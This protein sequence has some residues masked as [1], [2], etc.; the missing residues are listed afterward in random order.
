MKALILAAGYGTRLYSIIKDTPKALLEVNHK[1]LVNYI[2]DRLRNVKDLNEVI[3]VTNEK[4]ASIFEE[5]AAAQDYFCPIRIVNDGT[6]T[7]EDRLG[8]IG[9]IDFAIKQASVEDDLLVVGGDNLF[10]FNIEEYIVFAR[11]Q[12]KSVTIGCYDIE[13]IEGASKFGVV[14]VDENHRVTSFEEKPEHPKSTLISM[15]FYYLPQSALSLCEGYL[16]ETEKSDTAGDF[17]RWLL[18]K[19]DVCGFKFSG[20]W[21]DIGSVESYEEAQKEFLT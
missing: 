8:S 1:S 19:N 16:K 12:E 20:K 6:T 21:Y 2:L 13:D 5:W 7:P 10:N 17:I 15:C 3:L 11:S 9:D 14:A 18:N 4:F